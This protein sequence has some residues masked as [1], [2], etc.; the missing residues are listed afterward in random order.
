MATL[1]N[2]R[3][4]L[5]DLAKLTDPDGNISNVIEIL[6]QTNEMMADMTWQTGNL[7]DGHQ[8]TIR[9]GIPDPTWRKFNQG[10]Q[11]TKSSTAQ[12]KYGTGML[13]QLAEV[14]EELA[15]LNG[16]SAAWRLQEERPAIEGLNQEIQ[17]TLLFGNEKTE[18]E[19]FTG[20]SP[21]Y[22]SITA[23]SGDNIIDAGGTGSDNTSIWLVVW[24]SNSVYGIVPKGSVGGLQIEDAG[25]Q[26]LENVS[27]P[28]GG[29]NGRMKVLRTYYKWDVGL[30][31]V[32]WRFT[33]RIANIDKSLLTKDAATGA[34]L[35]DLMHTAMERIPNLSMGRPAFYMSRDTRTMLRK[36]LTHAR[37]MSD[38][39]VE[40]VGG[41]RTTMFQG[42]VPLRRVD[43][44]ASDEAR[45]T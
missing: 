1:D 20:F 17:E 44:L 10:I 15:A 32:D 38:L 2:T 12:V 33:V 16:N 19:A 3:L 31:M 43:V 18:P 45:V 14:D 24:G 7:V 27:T 37:S 42:I 35:P 26:W 5:L 36:Q 22:N 8:V 28:S 34:D 39:S 30:A 11:P 41:L 9:T 21:Y 23:E 4:S 6:N 40:E 29:S 13:R 25:T